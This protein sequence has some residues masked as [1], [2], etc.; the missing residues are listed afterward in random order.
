M[1]SRHPATNRWDE[2]ARVLRPGG[3]YLS[4]QID[5]GRVRELADAMLG[6]LPVQWGAAARA[7]REAAEAAGLDVVDLRRR[8]CG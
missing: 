7:V 1:T 6:P 8:R 3:G 2:I 4:Q 5:A